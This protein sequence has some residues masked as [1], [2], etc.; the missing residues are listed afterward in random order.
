M[1]GREFSVMGEVVQGDRIG[2]TLGFP[3]ANLLT[4]PR[5]VMPPKGV[6]ATRTEIDGT[7]YPSITNY[8]GKPTIK[9]GA[10][11]I[12]THVLDYSGNLYGKVIE[13]SF[14]EKLRDIQGF[15][16]RD[17]LSARLAADKIAAQAV[18]SDRGGF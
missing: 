12:E 17:A 6:Y 4:D 16:S 1:L 15:S 10:D 8:G 9:K 3:T 13:V 14:A 18:L 5:R 2:R 7:V 11:L